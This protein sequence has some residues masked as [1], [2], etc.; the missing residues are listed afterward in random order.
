MTRSAKL[1]LIFLE[2]AL[3]LTAN[4]K[5]AEPNVATAASPDAKVLLAETAKLE[6]RFST[7]S[8]KEASDSRTTKRNIAVGKKRLEAFRIVR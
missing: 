2:C 1:T 7:P 5:A 4:A 6:R 3:M 8:E